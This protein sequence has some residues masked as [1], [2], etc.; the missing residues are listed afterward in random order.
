MCT[1]IETQEQND[2]ALYREIQKRE[3]ESVD[4]LKRIADF[5]GY[6]AQRIKC[7]EE[8]SELITALVKDDKDNI[9]E[10]IADVEIMIAQIKYLL[11][12]HVLTTKKRKIDRQLGRIADAIEA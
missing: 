11:K 9:T 1:E 4:M 10:E 5:Y 12:L 7:V 3:A 6:D 2:P 8:L